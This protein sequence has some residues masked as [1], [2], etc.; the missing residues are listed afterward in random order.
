M[1]YMKI[2]WSF[3]TKFFALGRKSKLLLIIGTA[4]ILLA[5]VGGVGVYAMMATR[6][7]DTP[8]VVKHSEPG[9]K[10]AKTGANSPGKGESSSSE[11]SD[12]DSNVQPAVVPT[13]EPSVGAAS[14]PRTTTSQKK[15]SLD[16]SA[17]RLCWDKFNALYV[18]NQSDNA[19]LNAEKNAAV[20]EVDELYEE[21]F[22]RWQSNGDLTTAYNTWQIDRAEVIAD[23]NQQ[24]MT[25]YNNYVVAS[26]PYAN[27][28]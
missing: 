13:S 11:A 2:L 6:Q 26:A 1:R 23:Y 7:H 20:A 16:N 25:L 15:S 19:A 8:P 17:T 12:V 21:G 22:Y 18:K 3:R 9:T 4:G 28:G 24:L 10:Q 14:S 27:C 5:G